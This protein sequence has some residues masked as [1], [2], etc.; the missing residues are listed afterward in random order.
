[1]CSTCTPTIHTHV[2]GK[3]APASSPCT[4][5]TTGSTRVHQHSVPRGFY[6]DPLAWKFAKLPSLVSKHFQACQ[7]KLRHELS[8]VLA[9]IEVAVIHASMQTH[10][11]WFIAKHDVHSIQLARTSRDGLGTNLESHNLYHH[12]SI[13][14]WFYWSQGCYILVATPPTSRHDSLLRRADSSE[15]NDSWSCLLHSKSNSLQSQY[16]RACKFDCACEEITN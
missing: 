8:C 13:S 7:S 1:M 5:P 16:S 10:S 3:R 14:L 11:L 12:S 4:H 6:Y 9:S 15:R 2:T